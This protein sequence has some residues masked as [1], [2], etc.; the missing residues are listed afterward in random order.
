MP[1]CGKCGGSFPFL[2]NVSCNGCL[3]LE[4]CSV[5]E[6][7]SALEEVQLL[8]FP[9][10]RL[11]NLHPS[12]ERPYQGKRVVVVVCSLH[13]CGHLCV[14]HACANLQVGVSPYFPLMQG[15][16]IKIST[17]PQSILPMGTRYLW[18]SA[19]I[20]GS[21]NTFRSVVSRHPHRTPGPLNMLSPTLNRRRQVVLHM[22]L[23]QKILQALSFK[24]RCSSNK[25]QVRSE[26][27]SPRRP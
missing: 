19:V 20:R 21:W 1:D 10:H 6:E 4:N 23:A 17:R 9:C 13:L 27:A 8:L 3:A 5:P 14:V 15:M 24:P 2:T 12:S 18:S 7:K 16:L 25:P 26:L 22:A 11:T